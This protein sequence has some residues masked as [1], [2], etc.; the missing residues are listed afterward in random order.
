MKTYKFAVSLCN[1]WCTGY[2]HIRAE[3]SDEAYDKAMDIVAERLTKAFPT[4]GID[5]NVECD[6]PDEEY[7][8]AIEDKLV[9]KISGLHYTELEDFLGCQLS[10]DILDHLEDV[11]REILDQMPEEELL[12]YEQ[13]YLVE[14]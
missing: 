6:N 12:L 5:Y 10:F 3:N 1:G 7:Y 4:L 11:I 13:K 2:I 8:E 14:E 9:E